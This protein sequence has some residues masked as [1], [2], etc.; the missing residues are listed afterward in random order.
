MKSFITPV[1][2]P[3][4]FHGFCERHFIPSFPSFFK[5]NLGLPAVFSQWKSGPRK[6]A[7]PQG[8]PLSILAWA[9]GSG[10]DAHLCLWGWVNFWREEPRCLGPLGGG[11]NGGGGARWDGLRLFLGELCSLGSICVTC[12]WGSL[13][14]LEYPSCLHSLDGK[15]S[16]STFHLPLEYFLGSRV[17]HGLL[18]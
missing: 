17:C 11:V 18:V 15:F 4:L 9:A 8:C 14:N 5:I 16:P 10:L 12:C 1:P 13:R 2:H 7:S 6:E 3:P